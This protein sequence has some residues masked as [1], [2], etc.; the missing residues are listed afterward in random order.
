MTAKINEH[1]YRN[2]LRQ[3]WY[4]SERIAKM[5]L[6]QIPSASRGE[7]TKTQPLK[8]SPGIWRV[9]DLLASRPGK[10]VA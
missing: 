9:D 6:G 1:T 4:S 8:T 2:G 5:I 3:R 7:F 10:A